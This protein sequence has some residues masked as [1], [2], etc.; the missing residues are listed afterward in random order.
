M[1]KA[2]PSLELMS[3]AVKTQLESQLRHFDGL[4]AKAGIV[5]GFSGVLAALA[6]DES[7][8]RLPSRL[9]AA[10]AALVAMWSFLPRRFPVLDLRG[11]RE[12]YLRA[13]LEFAKLH[14]L[15]TMIR[16]EEQAS[17]VLERKARRLRLAIGLLAIAVVLSSGGTLVKGGMR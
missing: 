3:E 8:L 10:I 7:A 17:I 13:N 15:D 11:F 14:L 5:L 4:D 9:V 6:S 12:R 2:L 16:M 1:T